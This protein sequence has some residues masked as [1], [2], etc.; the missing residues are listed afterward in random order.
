MTV[1]KGL[2]CFEEKRGSFQDRKEAELIAR[3]GLA[4]EPA[5]KELYFLYYGRLHRFVSRFSG[6][7]AIDE[8]INDV[9]Y[10]VWQKA[11]TF[12]GSSLP[13]TWIFGIAF[14]K[15]RQSL[16][17]LAHAREESLDTLDGDGAELGTVDPGLQQLENESLL[18]E[19]FKTLSAEQRAVV[20]LTYFQ[21]MSYR[22]I[23]K[24]MDCSEN[25]V[26]TRM[27]HARLKLSKALQ[28]T[29]AVSPI[30]DE[31]NGSKK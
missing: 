10:I 19:A 4:D 27:F 9:M 30:P 12:N 25:T 23:A 6:V 22:E 31:L 2:D 26:K 8:I 28:G 29:R 24:V 14:N 20:E 21:G 13:S 3:I 7:L 17:G 18:G 1:A 16:R 11:K 15:T 5:L